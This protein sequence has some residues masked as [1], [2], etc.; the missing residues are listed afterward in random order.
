MYFVL[1]KYDKIKELKS[2]ENISE[3]NYRYGLL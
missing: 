2:L 3:E 1:G